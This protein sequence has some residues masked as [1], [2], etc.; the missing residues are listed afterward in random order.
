M[1]PLVLKRVTNTA[2]VVIDAPEGSSG[3]RSGAKVLLSE[4]KA[5]MVGAGGAQAGLAVAVDEEISA[6]MAGIE[7]EKVMERTVAK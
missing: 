4:P 3:A 6:E 7:K 2:M 5:M 1:L